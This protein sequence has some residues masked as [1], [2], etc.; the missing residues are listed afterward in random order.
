MVIKPNEEEFEDWLNTLGLLPRSIKN[1]SYYLKRFEGEINQESFNQFLL[2]CNNNIAR[3]FLKNLIKYILEHREQMNISKEQ[4]SDIRDI[5]IPKITGKKRM[6]IPE[7]I[8]PEEIE[9]IK[10]VLVFKTDKMVLELSYWSGLRLEE[11]TKIKNNDFK[12]EKFN[13]GVPGEP[14]EVLIHGKGGLEGI[15]IVPEWLMYSLA[16]F[17]KEDKKEKIIDD[18]Q[19]FNIT[20]RNWQRVLRKASKKAIGKYLHP[21][22]LRHGIASYLRYK[23]MDINDLKEFLRHKNIS[24][25]QIYVHTDREQ[26][27][28]KYR[29]Y[30]T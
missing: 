26:L 3:A 15:A 21:H 29:N 17:I 5:I 19:T 11:I 28:N 1:Y 24:N 20:M 4:M 13:K 27:K 23:G 16:K 12:W 25:T 14:G 30:I 6:K 2:S 18:I 10:E 9:K 8:Y 7:I 22:S